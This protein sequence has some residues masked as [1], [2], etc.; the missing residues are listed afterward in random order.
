MV[1]MKSEQ[2]AQ[3]LRGVLT[4]SRRLRAERPEGSASLSGISILG[5]LHRLGPM[6]ATRLA[7]EER[8]QPQ[9]LT[10]IIADLE[11][12]GW[13]D[14]TRNEA[15]RREILIALTPRGREVFADDM[16]ARRAWLADAMAAILTDGERDELL[17]AS[18]AMLK[19]AG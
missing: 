4:L 6:P 12:R 1:D 3:V 16:R 11:D 14:R 8:L 17:R 7:V 15:D 5:S 10:R 2:A 19:L 18:G 9:S 13:I